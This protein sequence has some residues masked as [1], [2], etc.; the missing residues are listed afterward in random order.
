[1]KNTA[2]TANADCA[3]SVSHTLSLAVTL[4]ILTPEQSFAIAG[5]IVDH[6]GATELRLADLS[7]D[8]REALDRLVMWIWHGDACGR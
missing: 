7:D 4:G 1:M 5:A 3:L 8:E 6:G 2:I